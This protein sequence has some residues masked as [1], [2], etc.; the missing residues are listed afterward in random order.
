VKRGLENRFLQIE[1]RACRGSCR[2]S[3]VRYM[4]GVLA[5]GGGVRSWL[6]PLLDDAAEVGLRTGGSSPRRARDCSFPG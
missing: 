3:F 6:L 2:I 1:D 4:D 5:Q